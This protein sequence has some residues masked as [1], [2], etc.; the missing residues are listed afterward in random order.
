MGK[1]GTEGRLQ[2]LRHNFIQVTVGRCWRQTVVGNGCGPRAANA[3]TISSTRRGR[4]AD[5]A[6]ANAS[7]MNPGWANV[8]TVRTLYRQ[9]DVGSLLLDGANVIGVRL[10]Q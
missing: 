1:Q 10:G 8:P 9:F 5:A 4:A 7:Y 6:E 2:S 3:A